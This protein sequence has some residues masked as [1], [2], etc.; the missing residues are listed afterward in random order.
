MAV[1]YDVQFHEALTKT[2]VK[3]A[4]NI[5]ICPPHPPKGT[6]NCGRKWPEEGINENWTIVYVGQNENF[7]TLL[8]FTFSKSQL[9][10]YDPCQEIF[11]ENTINLK[12]ALM[13]R[14]MLIEKTKDA[15]RIGILVG[16]LGASRYG[17]IIDQVRHNVKTAGKRVYTFLIGKPNVP[18]LAN[19]PGLSFF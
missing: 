3:F 10:C 12:R 19:F 18:K 16:T 9:V 14:Y 2:E 7:Q 5:F 6:G 13:K 11:I 8:S 17:D 1:V 15:D 4:E